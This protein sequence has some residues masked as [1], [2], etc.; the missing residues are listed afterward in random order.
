MNDSIHPVT[1]S[2]LPGPSFNGAKE[3]YANIRAWRTRH[4]LILFSEH[5]WDDETILLKASPEILGDSERRHAKSNLVWLTTLRILRGKEF[6]HMLYLEQDCRVA[7]HEWDGIV[8]NEAFKDSIPQI[9]GSVVCHSMCTVSMDWTRRW[10]NFIADH[11]R[12]RFPIPCIGGTGVAEYNEPCM[13]VNGALGIYD[14]QL[15]LKFFAPQLE[16]GKTSQAA[17]EMPAWDVA[18]GRM[19][20]DTYKEDIFDGRIR[21]L[22]SV[23][24]GYGNVQTTEAERLEWLVTGHCCAVHQVKAPVTGPLTESDLRLTPQ[25]PS[26]QTGER[27]HA[28]P[29]APDDKLTSAHGMKSPSAEQLD[30]MFV[31]TTVTELTKTPPSMDILI[32]S[33]APDADWLWYCLQSI[34]CFCTGFNQIVILTP[35]HDALA[36]KRHRQEFKGKY[37][38]KTYDEKP[39]PLGFLHHMVQVCRADEWCKAQLI[40]HLDSDCIVKCLTTPADYLHNGKPILQI[41]SYE[42]LKTAHP[43][44]YH[45]KSVVDAA[46]GGSATHCTMTRHPG[47]FPRELYPLVRQHIEELHKK[48]FDEYVFSCK[49]EWPHGLCEFGTLG[50]YAMRSSTLRDKFHFVE[51]TQQPDQNNFVPTDGSQAPKNH[52]AQ[53][54]SHPKGAPDGLD[55]VHTYGPGIPPEV[56]SHRKLVKHLGLV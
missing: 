10:T 29:D 15:M 19:M 46:L 23:Y 4:P 18:I 7:Q 43:G 47:V 20:H 42:H 24:S 9:A 55:R 54:F 21:H 50:A 37:R 34:R 2:Y 22:D 16:D 28:G 13:F 17:V 39:A 11:R 30:K 32:V 41:E 31:D 35:K 49:P 40:M 3:F 25:L 45:W 12:A 44:R 48:P 53:G 36:F 1:I 56:N 6:T 27:V 14:L 5:K 33:F 38:W 26:F 52:I 51:G 8:F